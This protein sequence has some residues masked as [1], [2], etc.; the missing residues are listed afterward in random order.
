MLLLQERGLLIKYFHQFRK[1]VDK[2]PGGYETLKEILGRDDIAT[3]Q[4]EWQVY[5]SK[6]RFGR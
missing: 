2:D 1:N 3:F 6:L 5:V 4:K